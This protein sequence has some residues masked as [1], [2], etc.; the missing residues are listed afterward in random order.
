MVLALFAHTVAAQTGSAVSIAIHDEQ[1]SPLA[2]A[3]VTLE[4][5]D[6]SLRR[7][8]AG[9][10]TVRFDDLPSG[11]Y[12]LSI[13]ATGF[14]PLTTNFTTAASGDNS[15]DA[16]LIPVS[17]RNDSVTVQGAIESPLEEGPSAATALSR[18]EVKNMPDRPATVRDA[19]SL[20]PGIVQLP[21]GK[22][23]LSG[24]GEHRSALLVNSDDATDPATGAFGATVPIDSVE[25]IRVLSSPFLAEYGGFSSSVVSVETRK[26]GEKWHFE[27]NDPLPEFRWR[28]WHMVGLRSL[29]PR[30]TFGGPLVHNRVY[31]LESVQYEYRANPII[32]LP[33]PDNQQRREA[34]NSFTEL[35]YTVSS[36]NLLTATLHAA[37]GHTRFANLDFFNPEP[38]SPN[39]A[40]SSYSADVTDH[41]SIRGTLLESSLTATSFRANVW[42]QGNLPMTLMPQGNV[43]NYFSAQ[44]RNS[45]RE[46]WRETWS[47]A[48]NFLG[49]HNLKFGSTVA[50][51]AEHAL[52]SER[53]VSIADASG[54]LLETIA[55]TPGQPIARTDVES[56]F[57]AQD[58]WTMGTRFA[59]SA[60]VRAE[61]QEV[62]ETFRVAPRAGFVWTPFKSARTIVRGGMGVFFDRVPLNVYGF[63]SYPDQTITRYAPDGSVVYG[64]QIFYNLTEQAAHADLPLIY[65]NAQLPG[66]FAPYS[67]NVNVQLEQ[68][69]SS[70]LRLRANYLE[71]R[72]G[73]LI[74]LNPQVT[75]AMSAYV[76]NG[77]GSSQ[78]K[79]FEMTA[80]ARISKR[81]QIYLS[82]VR[83]S[84]VGNLNE[85][86]NYLADFPPAVILPDARA[87]LPGDTPNRFLAWGTISLP[88]KIAVMPKIEYRSGFPWSTVDA[89]QSYVGAPDQARFPGYFSVDARVSKDFKVNEK[90]TVRFAVSGSNLTDHFNPVSVHSNLADPA[91]GV[92]F[93]EYRRRYTADFDVIF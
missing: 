43:G 49:T 58:Q 46:S 10:P 87:N 73:G 48:R 85:F 71:S 50:G 92:F 55:F 17:E 44:T 89:L 37:D 81:S 88:L 80:V 83:S 30:V 26:A 59:L 33:F 93:G 16:T 77:S 8:S 69:L 11:T 20:S 56:G 14:A 52:I 28:S 38:V 4:S 22:L 40:D 41:A 45:S 60:G 76:L 24:T 21:D 79:Q 12:Q 27:L 74:V 7:T 91:Y 86:S 67:T 64:P 23:S 65:R 32:T 63:S 9:A 13:E 57:F 18:D 5:A 66:N 82:Y 1:G 3:S 75:P 34:Y 42:G 39:T 68:I 25:T 54:L 19:L 62:T 2:S 15:I 70:N 51:T 53:P 84:A 78:V 47:L 31:L 90:Y 72:S 61:Q 35:D 36:S 6:H 29:T